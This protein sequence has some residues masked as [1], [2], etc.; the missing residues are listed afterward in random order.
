MKQGKGRRNS[1]AWKAR[2]ANTHVSSGTGKR[3]KNGM[4]VDSQWQD[5][6]RGSEAGRGGSGSG[7]QEDD[8]ALLGMGAT[9]FLIVTLRKMLEVYVSS[10]SLSSGSRHSRES[11]CDEAEILDILLL[12]LL[13]GGVAGGQSDKPESAVE[14]SAG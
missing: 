9:R 8:D 4:K 2:D 12:F 3:M 6:E 13:F 5:D 11:D 7:G 1:C 10:F 14:E